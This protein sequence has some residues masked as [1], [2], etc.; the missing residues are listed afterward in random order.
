MA[1]LSLSAT[2]STP[3]GSLLD[4][5]P[6]SPPQKPN[7]PSVEICR[8]PAKNGKILPNFD[9]TLPK[10]HFI[11]PNF[12]F[13]PP[14]GI[15]ICSLELSDFLGRDCNQRRCSGSYS[16]SIA[17]CSKALATYPVELSYVVP[18]REDYSAS[19]LTGSGIA[20]ALYRI[21]RTF[22]TRTSDTLQSMFT[23]PPFNI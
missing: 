22:V 3:S 18:R 1:P 2:I 12:H 6:N 4:S 9:S 21:K 23:P 8:F 10:F 17:L 11:L 13:G 20:F 7:N 16:D 15:F 19:A 14:W 5:A